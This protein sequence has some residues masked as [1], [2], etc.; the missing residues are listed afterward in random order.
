MTT[1]RAKSA[2]TSPVKK[3]V[4]TATKAPDESVTTVEVTA[5]PTPSPSPAPVKS[6]AKAAKTKAVAA[7]VKTEV[8]PDVVAPVEQETTQS[9]T[10][11]TPTPSTPTAESSTGEELLKAE[12]KEQDVSKSES[13]EDAFISKLSSFI[14]KLSFINK[15]VKE[16]QT[17]GKTLQKE[18]NNVIKVISKQKN[19][20]KKEHKNL[21]GFA[22]PSLLSKELYEFLN[23]E[24]GTRVARKDVT[25]MIHN[26][27]IANNLRREDNKRIFIPDDNLK[28]IFNCTDN[29]IVD[30]FNLQHYMKPHYIKDQP[31]AA[32]P[33]PVPVA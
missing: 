4:K 33:V 14:S 5:P 11:A 7:K 17:I 3:N 20:S 6:S 31:K 30:Y 16:L 12:S 1:T 10:T 8:V 9:T 32:V 13:V 18:F 19:K 25:K 21:S 2:K 28:R 24:E 27:I 29:D 22:M 23:I 26:Y 15:E